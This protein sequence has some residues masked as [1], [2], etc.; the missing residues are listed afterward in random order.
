MPSIAKTTLTFLKQIEKNN[1][2]P[3]FNEHKE[4]YLQAKTDFENF[5]KAIQTQLEKHDE[6][7]N[8]KT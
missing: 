6:I 4:R 2:R 3:W 8:T 7:E 1:N 5:F